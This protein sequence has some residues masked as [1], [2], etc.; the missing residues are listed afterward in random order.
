MLV[1]GTLAARVEGIEVTQA[2]QTTD[3]PRLRPA[4]VALVKH[5]KTVVRVFADFVGLEAPIAGAPRPRH[6]PVRRR[7][8]GRPS[9]AAAVSGVVAA[10]LGIVVNDLALT[11]T[12]SELVAARLRRAPRR[13]DARP[14]RLE[15]RLGS[16]D[17]GAAPR[18]TRCAWATACGA[19]P[20]RDLAG[21][22]FRDPP[23]AAAISAVRQFVV[24][25]VDSTRA[26]LRRVPT[27]TAR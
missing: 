18:A 17:D 15:A 13:L 10:V 8:E 1:Q 12:R 4:D 27:R 22:M 25:H 9:R 21:V 5:K 3:Q 14:I 16:T 23:R 7:R 20:T 19:M 11:P 6:G 2:V 26:T 24:D